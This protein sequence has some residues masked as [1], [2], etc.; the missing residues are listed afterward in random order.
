MKNF[1]LPIKGALDFARGLW[2]RKLSILICVALGASIAF[3]IGYN[4]EPMYEASTLILVESQKVP[5]EYVKSTVSTRI[6]ERL[7]TLEQQIINRS[8]LERVIEQADL[9]PDLRG[10]VPIE[11]LV[12]TVKKNLNIRVQKNQVF[13]ISF[14][15]SDPQSVAR[16]ANV[17]ADMFIEEN[18][19]LRASQAENTTSFLDSEMQSTKSL[20]Q[21]QEAKLSEFRLANY[22]R[23]P[24]QRDSNFTALE[25]LQS[26][27]DIN[28]G[29]IERAELRRTFLVQSPAAIQQVAPAPSERSRLQD[30]TLELRRLRAQ[31]TDE[32]PDIVRLTAEIAQLSELAV[33][34][35]GDPTSVDMALEEASRQSEIQQV[36]DEI[37]RLRSDQEK[38]I[39]EMAVYQ[40]RLESTPRVEQQLISLTRDY[41]TLRN[42]YESLLEK[43]T[44]A[45]L[46]ENLERSQQGE[47]FR[48]LEQAIPPSKPRS[49]N[50]FFLMFGGTIIGLLIGVTFG[51]IR[52]Q[53]DETFDSEAALQEAFPGLA[54][55]VP[56]PHLE[57][58]VES[59][60]LATQSERTSSA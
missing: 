55:I 60:E 48:K 32:H 21:V 49:P 9:Y 12:S 30:L 31:Y 10:V 41:S 22:G 46:A 36:D 34:E 53:T 1:Q 13:R 47:Q 35:S 28:R 2:R 4:I 7:K 18:L 40:S 56:V 38:I 44:E 51:L 23:L 14:R 33:P 16:A 42:S 59:N 11:R 26:K 39:Q 5:A 43:R 19:R 58:A 57:P 6:E 52:D 29:A 24:D 17:I 3:A 54:F 15:G 25:Q 37:A 27:F 50:W 8:N 45:R 20:L